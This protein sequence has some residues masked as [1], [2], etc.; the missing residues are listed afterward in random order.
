MGATWV[1]Q[2]HV[3]ECNELQHV[4]TLLRKKSVPF[5]AFVAQIASGCGR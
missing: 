1:L 3:L 4:T 2:G 5:D